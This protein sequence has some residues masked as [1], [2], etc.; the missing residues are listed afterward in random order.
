LARYGGDEFA[1]VLAGVDL[2][3]AHDIAERLRRA[4]ADTS[5]QVRDEVVSL[6]IS[7]GVA[8]SPRHGDTPET[9]LRAADEAL[10][11]AKRRGG[12][13]IAIAGEWSP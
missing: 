2:A 7:L 1:V 10:Y 5:F 9:L 3:V 6:T 8:A 13:T 11:A 12:N 4:V